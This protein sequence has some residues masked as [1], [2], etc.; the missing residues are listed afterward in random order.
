MND[1]KEDK[2]MSKLISVIVPCYNE[3]E[4]L[5]LFYE[6]ITRVAGKMPN[7]NFEFLFVN[8][9]SK[10]KTLEILKEFAPSPPV[11]TISRTSISWSSLMQ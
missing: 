1:T 10:D 9:G 2:F 4:V 3:Q 8:D 7:Y 6:E 11:P 5:H